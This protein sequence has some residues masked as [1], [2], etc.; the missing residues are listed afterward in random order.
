CGKTFT[1]RFNL[2]SHALV[3]S[4]QRPFA[5][6]HC[7]VTFRRKHDLQR[8]TRSLHSGSRPWTCNFC[9]LGFARSDALRRH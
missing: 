3:H 2:R 6:S 7:S 8:H 4:E 9:H 1:R 5:C